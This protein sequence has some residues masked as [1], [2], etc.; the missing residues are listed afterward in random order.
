MLDNI[1]VNV[2]GSAVRLHNAHV[3]LQALI[4]RR[5]AMVAANHASEFDGSG[6][7]RTSTP[8]GREVGRFT[9]GHHYSRATE[10]RKGERRSP[11]TEFRPGQTAHNKLPVGSVCIRKETHT[12]LKRAW[13]KVSEPNV[14]KKRAVVV[15]EAHHG[16]VPRGHVVHHRDRNSLND[17]PNNLVALTR[18]RH[19]A[20]HKEDLHAW[21]G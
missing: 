3:E 15:W 7:M 9:P 8:Q 13:V 5:L 18:R 20:V 11:A 16:P 14:W 2:T 12:G 1:E 4:S 10:I 6:V 19:A 17:E 21:R